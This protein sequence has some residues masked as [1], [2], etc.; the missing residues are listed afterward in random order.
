MSWGWTSYICKCGGIIT[1][2]WGSVD[3]HITCDSCNNPLP[4]EIQYEVVD[5][6][7]QNETKL[8]V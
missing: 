5:T 8:E 7:S 3:D 2:V 1:E 6:T 4:A